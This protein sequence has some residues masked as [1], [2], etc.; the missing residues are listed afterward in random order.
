MRAAG[1]PGVLRVLD[2]KRSQEDPAT[3][4]TLG[5]LLCCVRDALT[6]PAKEEMACGGGAELV[7]AAL[8]RHGYEVG[9]AVETLERYVALMRDL[10]VPRDSLRGLAAGDVAAL[11]A[12]HG[13]RLL[14]GA[15]GAPAPDGGGG[16]VLVVDAA[17]LFDRD[18]GGGGKGGG[19]EAAAVGRL[20]L[21]LR[22]ILAERPELALLGATVAVNVT[23]ADPRRSF[24]YAFAAAAHRLVA[25][26]PVPLR[27]LV[28]F[29]PAANIGTG[30]QTALRLLA[31]SIGDRVVY[32][33]VDAAT[34]MTSVTLAPHLSPY[35]TAGPD[36]AGRPLKRRPASAVL[37]DGDGVL[38]PRPASA[39]PATG[40]ESGR[41]PPGEVADF[42]TE[43]HNMAQQ[44]L[45]WN[46]DFGLGWYDPPDAA[47]A[48]ARAR[49][50]AVARRIRCRLAGASIGS[51]GRPEDVLP[52]VAVLKAG[53]IHARVSAA[54][55]L[56]A[57]C[58]ARHA[59]GKATLAQC[60]GARWL[61]W[62]LNGTDPVERAA[63]AEALAS[64]CTYCA[65]SA[66]S[67]QRA[68]AVP[69][70]LDLMTGCEAGS[71]QRVLAEALASVCENDDG[72]GAGEDVTRS[73]VC[74]VLGLLARGGPDEVQ[75]CCFAALAAALSSVEMARRDLLQSNAG[76]DAIN[77]ALLS[78]GPF[79]RRGAA[80]AVAALC[81]DSDDRYGAARLMQRLGA[82]APLVDHVSSL[83][84]AA[85][86]DGS[87]ALA[88]CCQASED[89]ARDLLRHGGVPVL[90]RACGRTATLSKILFRS[91]DKLD[92]H[93][94]TVDAVCEEWFREDT[95]SHVS[96]EYLD[97]CINFLDPWMEGFIVTTDW[98]KVQACHLRVFTVLLQ[99]D[100]SREDTAE[101]LC[102]TKG[103]ISVF[104]DLACCGDVR[105]QGAA[106]S[107]ITELAKIERVS[108]RVVSDFLDKGGDIVLIDVI[109]RSEDN[110]HPALECLLQLSQASAH[111]RGRIG[112]S[113][114]LK[115]ISSISTNKPTTAR[116]S[117][118]IVSSAQQVINFFSKGDAGLFYIM[119]NGSRSA[120]EKAAAA[121]WH[122]SAHNPEMKS[123]FMY[124]YFH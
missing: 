86:T 36:A 97:S 70:L 31:P 16:L 59:G 33:N 15:D 29:G 83:D 42:V 119:R 45:V 51:V 112:C 105:V 19:A 89:C 124:I 66:A 24:S 11:D 72:P 50:A 94:E 55:L 79:A 122:L 13:L 54:R 60:G 38:P 4:A 69:R 107:V 61:A 92:A 28:L 30:W 57:V 98:S 111:F 78:G 32:A 81:C 14:P 2:S 25:A 117:E 47:A 27:R 64:G 44:A 53:S 115:K 6:K 114:V 110:I 118:N 46:P 43:E 62:M 88:A 120:Q 8:R 102:H 106:F 85:E 104:S 96:E 76:P 113:G 99:K 49:L 116:F 9:A 73:G 56:A 121:V 95:G 67:A 65:A 22:V 37:R 58:R 109:N 100:C 17:R 20:V 5:R 82:I 75:R 101:Q 23:R 93:K 52:A 80:Q 12:E 26:F 91:R 90:A 39:A 74:R 34:A 123:S 108:L 103:T 3:L 1:L 48:D 18:R 10:G 63:A 71:A 87:K 40:E 35:V 84:P 21:F 41:G 7:A 68:G 77:S